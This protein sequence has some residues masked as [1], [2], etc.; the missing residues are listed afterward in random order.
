MQNFTKLIVDLDLKL[1]PDLSFDIVKRQFEIGK[2]S[3][4]MYF[5]DGYIKDEIYEKIYEFFFKIT[6]D[7]IEEIKNMERFSEVKT[8]YLEVEVTRNVNTACNAVLSGP[9]A[10]VIDGVDGILLLDTRTY[11]VRSIKEPDKDKSLRG[12]RDGFVET[13]I[14]NTALLRRRVR[15][16]RLR[17]ECVTV[18]K[19]S[20]VDIA[21]AYIDGVADKKV[22]DKIKKALNSIEIDGISMTQQAVSESLIKT[23]FFNPFPRFKFTER[24]DYA[25]A[26]LLDGKI[27]LL[28][29]N[30]PSVMILPT[31]FFDFFKETNDYYFPPLIGSYIRILRLA[32]SLLTVLL[33]PM[34]FLILKHPDVIP[35][36]LNFLIP[37]GSAGISIFLQFILLELLIDGLK[38]A[39]LNTP[40]TLSNALGIIGGLL[41][42]ELAI[43]AGWF[44]IQTVLIMS[45]VAIS[46]YTQP[47]FEMGYAMKFQRMVLLVLSE[48]FGFCGLIFGIIFF[49]ILAFSSKTV[50]GNNYLYPVVPIDLKKLKEMFFRSSLYKRR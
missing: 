39:S 12:S 23:S 9:A 50:T 38:L 10:L 5:I 7:E 22:L 28:M 41:L 20:K 19:I 31:S 48:I 46:T 6:A 45:F 11:P 25:S 26:A 21:V 24:P 15:D 17:Y 29:D 2:K 47:S 27:I 33:I 35:Q 18:G 43:S 42:S 8:P 37:D 44:N 16:E 13:L 1:R 34:Y 32:V 36:C 49:V 3:A 40:D 14:F 4:V 30:S